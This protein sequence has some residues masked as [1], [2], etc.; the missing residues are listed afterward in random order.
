M[1][2]FG[3]AEKWDA[4]FEN[5]EASETIKCSDFPSGDFFTDVEEDFNAVSNHPTED[6]WQHEELEEA[7]GI[8]NLNA[9]YSYGGATP[10]S[11]PYRTKN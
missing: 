2:D 4:S 7:F 9:F 6:V 5:T 8:Y 10:V 1:A 3:I 11:H